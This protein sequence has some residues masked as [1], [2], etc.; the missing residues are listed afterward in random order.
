MPMMMQMIDVGGIPALTDN[1]READEDNPKGYYELEAVKRTRKD[2]SWLKEAPGRVVKMVHVLLLD[3]HAGW[4][5]KHIGWTG[6][7]REERMPILQALGLADY[8]DKKRRSAAEEPPV[9]GSGTAPSPHVPQRGLVLL[10]KIVPAG[11]WG[12]YRGAVQLWDGD[13]VRPGS[14]RTIGLAPLSV[15][16]WRRAMA[17]N[18]WHAGGAGVAISLLLGN[19][20]YGLQAQYSARKYRNAA[21]TALPYGINTPSVIAYAFFIMGPVYRET[22]DLHAVVDHLIAETHQ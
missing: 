2:A 13:L 1:I 3:L 19:L 21:C 12:G 18:V 15:G 4:R 5:P 6:E 7:A 9:G 8:L 20:F 17:I 11:K 10:E 22:G 16:S 14:G